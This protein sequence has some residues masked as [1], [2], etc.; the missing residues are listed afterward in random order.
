MLFPL[1]T[2]CCYPRTVISTGLSTC[3]RQKSFTP[4]GCGFSISSSGGGYTAEE[5]T[6]VWSASPPSD[7]AFANATF[8]VGDTPDHVSADIVL[9]LTW[10]GQT[11][12]GENL[13]ATLPNVHVVADFSDPDN[14]TV[15]F[16]A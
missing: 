7:Q 13:T 4:V 10:S 16:P 14:V 12:H 6:T 8:T 5:S 15:T 3:L 2:E 9:T 1:I 11:A